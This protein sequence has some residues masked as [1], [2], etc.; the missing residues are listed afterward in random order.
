MR[1]TLALP[2]NLNRRNLLSFLSLSPISRKP[3]PS[4][5]DA[6]Q[7]AHS[8]PASH[9]SQ[10]IS[11]ISKIIRRKL[12]RSGFSGDNPISS[13]ARNAGRLSSKRRILEI[14]PVYDYPLHAKFTFLSRCLNGR[15]G[16]LGRVVRLT[17]ASH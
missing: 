11:A 6:R 9:R 5:Y 3:Q 2:K 16:N 7:S 10:G 8:R 15:D 13:S 14:A 4:I 1:Y 12:R 17:A